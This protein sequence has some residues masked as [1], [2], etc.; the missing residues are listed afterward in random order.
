MKTYPLDAFIAYSFEICHITCAMLLV[1]F[2]TLCSCL[3]YYL[4][5]FVISL[6]SILCIH[7]CLVSDWG[8]FGIYIH[9]CRILLSLQLGVFLFGVHTETHTFEF[10]CTD[11]GT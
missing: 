1:M 9:L 4:L 11:L 2:S 8:Y 5:I 10:L 3:W 7:N 6:F